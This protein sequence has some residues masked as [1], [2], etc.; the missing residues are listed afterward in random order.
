MNRLKEIPIPIAGLA[1]GVLGL[2]NILPNETLKYLCGFLGFILILTLVLK[3][4]KYL[5]LIRKD[6]ENPTLAA[7]F[8]TFPMALMVLS[9]YFLEGFCLWAV[10]LIIHVALIIYYSIKFLAKCELKTLHA[11]A[12]IVYIGI[13]I[14][15]ITGFDY[16]PAIANFLLIFSAASAIILV[17][18]LGYRYIK[19]PVKDPLKPL[20]CI[21]SAPASL[22][23]VAYLQSSLYLSKTVLI[24]L[25]VISIILFIFSI[26]KIIQYRKLDFY[27]SYSA[28]TFPFVITANATLNLTAYF[29]Q[30]TLFAWIQLI[31]AIILLCYVL[32]RYIKRY[33]FKKRKKF[34]INH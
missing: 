17:P 16:A 7:V 26:A 4:I 3:I 31:I 12:F 28:Y 11:S 6:F 22:I 33:L 32:M 25:L 9:T 23:I 34:I 20:I 21:Y 8:G 19:Y 14:A 1:L 2:G 15:T 13:G 18:L 30:I 27:P 5:N 24:I 10:G 29:P